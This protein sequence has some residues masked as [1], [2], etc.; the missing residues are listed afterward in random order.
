M[1]NNGWNTVDHK[2]PAEGEIVEVA[3]IIDD[4]F[5]PL[6][7][8]KVPFMVTHNITH[9]RYKKEEKPMKENEWIKFEDEMPKLNQKIEVKTEHL[10]TYICTLQG[11]HYGFNKFIFNL[12]YENE[13]SISDSPIWWR[14]LPDNSVKLDNETRWIEFN[15]KMPPLNEEV[16]VKFINGEIKKSKLTILRGDIAKSCEKVIVLACGD[17]YED[18]SR[19]VSWLTIKD[20]K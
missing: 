6:G 20:G 8:K 7:E 12:S 5:I 17:I 2:L 19:A 14:P 11:K 10:K 15:K 18:I 13:L 1:I 3:S 16:K 4:V 9:W